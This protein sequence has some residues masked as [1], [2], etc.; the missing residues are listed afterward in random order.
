MGS[1]EFIE[2]ERAAGGAARGLKPKAAAAS[3]S[4]ANRPSPGVPRTR[5]R[6]GQL[7]QHS[8]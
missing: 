7:A 6:P 8:L 1:N 3:A 5:F 4:A 2:H